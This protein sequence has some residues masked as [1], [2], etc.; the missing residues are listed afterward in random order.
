MCQELR[1]ILSTFYPFL[2]VLLITISTK[3][4]YFHPK[5]KSLFREI[6]IFAIFQSPPMIMTLKM[7]ILILDF[8]FF[9]IL[10]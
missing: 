2:T 10:E 3:I 9:P 5:S 4:A 6:E 8:R 1:S 7:T